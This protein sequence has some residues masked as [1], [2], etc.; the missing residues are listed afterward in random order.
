[1]EDEKKKAL[2]LFVIPAQAVIHLTSGDIE[3]CSGSPP[4]RG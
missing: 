2:S 1:M 4:M 3:C